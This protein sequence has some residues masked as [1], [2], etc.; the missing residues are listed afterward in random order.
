MLLFIFWYMSKFDFHFGTHLYLTIILYRHT[1]WFHYLSFWAIWRISSGLNLFNQC[2][3]C[4]FDSDI[5]SQYHSAHTSRELYVQWVDGVQALDGGT[6]G[7]EGNSCV[8]PR[9]SSLGTKNQ[10]RQLTGLSKGQTPCSHSSPNNLPPCW[11]TNP[12]RDLS[13]QLWCLECVCQIC[14]FYWAI[15]P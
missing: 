8:F 7:A 5:S 15:A 12:H 13:E 1:A 6:A 9:D 11:R 14:G 4:C 10:C 3:Y 2:F